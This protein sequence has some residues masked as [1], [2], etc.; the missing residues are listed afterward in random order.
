MK[1]TT[2]PQPTNSYLVFLNIRNYSRARMLGAA[3]YVSDLM[4][5]IVVKEG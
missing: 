3:F 4:G 2:K 5:Q 1:T